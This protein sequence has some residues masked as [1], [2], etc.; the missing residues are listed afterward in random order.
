ME[1]NAIGGIVDFI[2]YLE[3][4]GNN[5]ATIIKINRINIL[6]VDKCR[7]ILEV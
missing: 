4:I 1:R 6:T 7:T 2:T 5:E 3:K